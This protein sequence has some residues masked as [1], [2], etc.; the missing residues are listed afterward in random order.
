MIAY[1]VI[2][3]GTIR[4]ETSLLAPQMRDSVSGAVL[5]GSEYSVKRI[6]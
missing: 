3:T 5:R 1:L 4:S 2:F 6:P